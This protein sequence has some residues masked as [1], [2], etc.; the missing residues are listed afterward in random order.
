MSRF[1]N[2]RVQGFLQVDGT[3]FR[4]EAGQ[5]VILRGYGAGNWMNPEGFMI[6][7]SKTFGGAGLG[8]KE[9][10]LPERFDRARSVD[11][12]IRE[13]CGSTYQ[14]Q[15]WP[16][17]Y[18]NHLAEADIRTMAE[19]DFNSVRLP[20]CAWGFLPEE[21]EICWNEDSFSMLSDVLDWCETYRLY[22]ILDLHAA[23]GGQ[24]ALPCDDGIDNRPHMFTEPES[25]ERTMLLWEEL[26]RRFGNRWIVAGYNLLNEPIS[27]PS[28]LSLMPELSS[29]YD[30]LIDRIRKIDQKHIFFLEGATFATN[31]EIFDHDY[32]PDYHNWALTCHLYGF[33]PEIKDL[34]KFLL[35]SRRWNVPI[36]IGEGGSGNQEMTVFYE[37]AQHYSISI[38]LWVWKAA[39]G[40]DGRSSG[41]ASYPLPEGW[42]QM[43]AYFNEGGPRPS[44]AEAQK[45]MDQ[46][47]ENLKL[48]HCTLDHEKPR[49]VLRHCGI[50]VPGAG[51][52]AD[53][54][55][56]SWTLGNFMGYRLEDRTKLVLK[57]GAKVPSA[58]PAF[59]NSFGPGPLQQLW[60]E[61]LPGDYASYTIRDSSAACTVRLDAAGEGSVRLSCG[62]QSLELS[63]HGS[64][65]C[66]DIFSLPA[67]EESTVRIEGLSGSVQ[68]ASVHFD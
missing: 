68:I 4:N 21:P 10:V 62:K 49:Y 13:L 66:Y 35:V 9:L 12:T 61:L 11:S 15:F 24:S 59:G 53:G 48:E 55:H 20:L 65:H 47:L 33:S 42:E 50:T 44:Y 6:G 41:I 1:T 16:R 27:V 5:E 39:A 46:Y 37:L 25:R 56:G 54:F 43:Q 58:H 23:P 3:C 51:Y 30:E 17:W 28:S 52:D 32:D 40:P 38:N 2:D 18:R 63:V 26:A 34:Y 64:L 60:L 36:W 7:A 19:M 14:K 29:F 57:P 67:A 45:I 22:A 8:A 31:V